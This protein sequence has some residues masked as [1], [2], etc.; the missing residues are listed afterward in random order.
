[1]VGNTRPIEVPQDD[2]VIRFSLQDHP[3]ILRRSRG[4]AP[5]VPAMV[6]KKTSA[7]LATGALLKSSVALSC[8]DYYF[9][10]QYLGNTLV[11]EAQQ[12]FTKLTTHLLK[13][14]GIQP[15]AFI[16]D[17]HPGYFSNTYAQE[18]AQ[19]YKVPIQFVQ[20]HKAHAAAIL[21]E[22]DLLETTK[23][24]LCV[25]WDG[26]GLGDDQQIWGSEFF[27]YAHKKLSRV[28]HLPAFSV[29]SNDQMAREPR[30]SALSVLHAA[31]IDA[32]LLKNHFTNTEWN[33]YQKALQQKEVTATTSM[34]RL[35]DAVS[36]IL[37][38]CDKQQFEGQA[39]MLL[40]DV[41][42]QYWVQQPELTL[43]PYSIDWES[44]LWLA[45]LLN[46]I[47][48]DGKQQ[49]A[50]SIAFRFHVTLI[51]WI[52]HI[53]AKHQINAIACSGGVWQNALLVSLATEMMANTHQLLFHQHFSAN[54]ENV[55]F[56]QLV[57]AQFELA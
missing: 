37:G 23:E 24:V 19:Q 47:I 31:N 51:Y 32:A 29:L 39:A 43:V 38:L 26:T 36:C 3:I 5:S 41:A 34:G 15:K 54:D 49:P 14:T 4:L 44:N 57:Y 12:T 16:S 1:M 8:G 48:E 30:L 28:A 21:A 11:W 18:L 33:Y 55:S 40:E 52:K 53:A 25:I 20:H 46:A 13:L 22:H 10:S 17:T 6:N 27:V 35:F 2:S 56:G 42:N 50:N 9:V 7:L 45:Q